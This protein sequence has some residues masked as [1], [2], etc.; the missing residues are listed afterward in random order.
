MSIIWETL[1]KSKIYVLPAPQQDSSVT[2]DIFKLLGEWKLPT[3]HN[4]G[5]GS[6]KPELI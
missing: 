1:D 5:A 2:S 4:R 6:P 3:I